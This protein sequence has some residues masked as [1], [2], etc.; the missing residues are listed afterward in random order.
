MKRSTWLPIQRVRPRPWY[1]TCEIEVANLVSFL[2]RW[3]IVALVHKYKNYYSFS[4][5]D[6][7]SNLVKKLHFQ[8]CDTPI[9][10]LE[11]KCKTKFLL[12]QYG[13]WQ[14]LDFPS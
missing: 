6:E 11:N 1:D 10:F 12:Q 9:A 2:E 3:G 5:L 13:P 14:L 7:S 4:K 8:N